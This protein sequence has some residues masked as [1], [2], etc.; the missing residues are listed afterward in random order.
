MS[1][2]ILKTRHE[3]S[4][5]ANKLNEL[6]FADST[7]EQSMVPSS[8]PRFIKYTQNEAIFPK[9]PPNIHAGRKTPTLDMTDRHHE[10]ISG[11]AYQNEYR[12]KERKSICNLKE[13]LD[14]FVNNE[15][16]RAQRKK[17][18]DSSVTSSRPKLKKLEEVNK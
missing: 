8:N 13:Q 7:Y 11:Y 18:A 1:K 3:L 16:V 10:S 9:E 12:E 17:R 6:K 2:D 5:L 15:F 4:R 14:H